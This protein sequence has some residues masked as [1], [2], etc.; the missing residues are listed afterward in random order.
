MMAVDLSECD[1][2]GISPFLLFPS[3]INVMIRNLY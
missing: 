2:E 1:V 3:L